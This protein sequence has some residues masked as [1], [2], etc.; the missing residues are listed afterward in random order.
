MESVRKLSIGIIPDGNRKS[1]RLKGITLP[2]SYTSGAIIAGS[3]I[4]ESLRRGDIGRIVFYALSA[5]NYRE[6]KREEIDAVFTGIEKGLELFS[7]LEGVKT[8]CIGDPTPP[9]IASFFARTAAKIV[10][11]PKLIVSFLF[12]Y[13]P[14]WDFATRPIGSDSIPPLDLIIRHGETRLSGFLPVQSANAQ[15]YFLP[16]YWSDFTVDEFNKTVDH[17]KATRFN[18]IPGK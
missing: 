2:E 17:Y 15:L 16:G 7:S 14:A 9:K 13:T 12:N 6:R 4:Q 3:I 8:E 1:A 11:D 10:P 5:E 18:A